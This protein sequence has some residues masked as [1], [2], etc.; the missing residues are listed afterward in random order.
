MVARPIQWVLNPENPCLKTCRLCIQAARSQLEA[1][2]QGAAA[3]EE[4]AAALRRAPGSSDA[5]PSAVELQVPFATACVAQRRSLD[6]PLG[7][8]DA[9]S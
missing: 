3:A 4:A 1:A 5:A 7:E 2:Q 8:I 9:I 6:A